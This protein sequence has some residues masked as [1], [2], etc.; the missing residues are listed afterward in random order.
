MEKKRAEQF[1]EKALVLQHG[2][3]KATAALKKL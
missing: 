1:F 3:V 2:H